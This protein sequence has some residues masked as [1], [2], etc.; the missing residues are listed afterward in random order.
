MRN[1][2]HGAIETCLIHYTDILNLC[3]SSSI[4]SVLSTAVHEERKR[5]FLG[6]L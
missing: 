6:L 1:T 4:Y 2:R 5:R 3:P